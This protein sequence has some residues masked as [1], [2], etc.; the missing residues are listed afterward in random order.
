MDAC[1]AQMIGSAM[2]RD[3]VKWSNIG[4]L[5]ARVSLGFVAW[6]MVSLVL[7][8]GSVWSSSTMVHFYGK[9]GLESYIVVHVI[10]LL[11]VPFSH[12]LISPPPLSRFSGKKVTVAVDVK[13]R[14]VSWMN[15]RRTQTRFCDFQNCLRKYM[16][17]L[18]LPYRR[19]HAVKP[20]SQVKA[21]GIWTN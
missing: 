6:T 4:H 5:S 18:L 13:K 7:C 17:F 8:A 20:V 19:K 14:V 9:T 3:C 1:V 10:T 21:D 16:I 11:R 12:I 15:G 2:T